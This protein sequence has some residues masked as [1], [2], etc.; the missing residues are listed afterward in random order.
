MGGLAIESVNIFTF[1]GLSA[2]QNCL[3]FYFTRIL[4]DFMKLLKNFRFFRKNLGI[5]YSK[6]CPKSQIFKIKG[7]TPKH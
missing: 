6:N 4:R 7:A 5:L 3:I 2:C 1:F